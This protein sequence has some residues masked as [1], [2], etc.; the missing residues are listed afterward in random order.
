MFGLNEFDVRLE[1]VADPLG[2][3]VASLR[4]DL[5]SA[6]ALGRLTARS[7][8]VTVALASGRAAAFAHVRSRMPSSAL[9]P[10]PPELTPN[11]K[12]ARPSP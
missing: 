1:E 5:D 2:R 8:I 9:K 6:D 7:K 12:S 10:L 3:V 11:R 4:V